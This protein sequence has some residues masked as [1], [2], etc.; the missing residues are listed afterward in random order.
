MISHLSKNIKWITIVIVCTLLA[1]VLFL[2]LS[3]RSPINDV[4]SHEIS[5]DVM[6]CFACYGCGCEY[7][8]DGE[9]SYSLDEFNKTKCIYDLDGGQNGKYHGLVVE[10]TQKASEDDMTTVTITLEGNDFDEF[11]NCVENYSK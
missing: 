11:L 8:V 3:N 2:S 4:Q 5:F 10:L 9:D 6:G 7:T 1:F